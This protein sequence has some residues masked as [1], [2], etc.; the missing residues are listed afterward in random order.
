MTE[1]PH[2]TWCAT[3]PLAFLPLHAAGRYATTDQDKAF[4][5]VVSSYTP[6]LLALKNSYEGTL[7]PTPALLAV[8]QPKTPNLSSLPG[9][10]AEVIAIQGCI[11]G[12][13]LK[14]LNGKEATVSAVLAAMDE[15]NWCHFACHGIQHLED[16][17][18][19]AF[20]LEDGHLDLR[21]IMSKRFESAEIAFLSACQTATGDENRPEE[22]VHLA[23]GMLM[24]G[25]RTIFA[26][27]WSIGDRDG[28]VVAKEVY[29]YLMKSP[30]KDGNAAY[31]LHHAVE[32]LRGRLDGDSF[33]R[34]LPFVHFGA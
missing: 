32:V 8:S 3:G 16:P 9:T 20:A 28:P 23:A 6:T 21:T 11:E 2:I 22:A 24:A 30:A 13:E 4:Q 1:L 27:M 5:Y 17:T 29:T 25:F 15:C 14:W 10:E 7:R 33:V 26:T 12:M 19:S 18:K 31:A 34:W